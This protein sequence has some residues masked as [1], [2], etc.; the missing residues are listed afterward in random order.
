[1]ATVNRGWIHIVLRFVTGSCLNFCNH[2]ENDYKYQSLFYQAMQE[3]KTLL[4]RQETDGGFAR[5]PF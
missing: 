5:I 2:N 3:E 4:K 1:M